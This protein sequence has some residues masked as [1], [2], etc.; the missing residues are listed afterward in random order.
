LRNHLEAEHRAALA[1]WR[2][3]QEAGYV[4][5]DLGQALE[6]E[7]SEVSWEAVDRLQ[8]A[9]ANVTALGEREI[10]LADIHPSRWQPRAIVFDAEQLWELAK[11][12]E[13]MGL[14]NA[15]SVFRAH[16]GYELVAGERRTRAMVGL[17]L[18]KHLDRYTPKKCVERLARFGLGGLLDE[19]R[20]A[21]TAH[22]DT[23][24]A[25]V[26]PDGDTEHL[27]LVAVMENIDRQALTPLE[28][29][30]AFQG[31]VED[32][33]WSQRELARRIGKSQGY[34]Q[35]RLA[36]TG[37]TEAAQEAV[38][39]RV[40]NT[41]HARA[42]SSVPEPLQEA[43]TEWA[44]AAV[45]RSDT[46][47]TTRQ[48][49]NRARQVAAFVDPDRW[50]P[51]GEV[52]YRPLERNRLAAIRWALGLADLEWRSEEILG[53]GEVGYSEHNYLAQR[54]RSVVNNTYQFEKVLEALGVNI[55][56]DDEA[57]AFAMATNRTCE[58]CIFADTDLELESDDIP[59][60]CPRWVNDEIEACWEWIGA[61][62]PVVIPVHVYPLN[63]ILR[64]IKPAG[65]YQEPFEHFRN[66][67]H[68]LSA[69]E[70]A[71]RHEEEKARR[72]E[73]KARWGHVDVMRRFYAWQQELTLLSHFQAHACQKCR[74]YEPLN[75]EEDLPPCR[76][77]RDPLTDRYS[78]DV[79]APEYGAL[80]TEAL[81]RAIVL[82]RCEQFAYAELPTMPHGARI[83]VEEGDRS[84][85]LEW[86]MAI[87][88][89]RGRGYDRDCL[90][91]VLRWLPYE[92]PRDEAQNWDRLTRYLQDLWARI[93]PRTIATLFD[94]MISETHARQGYS[95]PVTLYN[96]VTGK[97]ETWYPVE[98]N[99]LDRES[100][101]YGRPYR[102]AAEWP[103]LWTDEEVE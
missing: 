74:H 1:H 98:F 75:L 20:L 72:Q 35:Q 58:S 49:A 48:V 9:I 95:G 2:E 19:E 97:E 57:Q 83:A 90:W 76:F 29:G 60:H 25:N 67:Q 64:E 38:N 23:I 14:I 66:V 71:I 11:S 53:L 17:A 3:L 56:D 70:A 85:V 39:T 10:S 27:H 12:I 63:S 43:V 84:R 73:E 103:D 15:I 24:R 99:R 42:I 80:V 8:A 96:P 32:Y 30:V 16:G 62:D 69:Y 21:L 18:G 46:P 87:A 36:L 65:W 51:N 31:L 33:D 13:E 22:G 78:D 92:R 52:I 59:V 89:G 100:E 7:A 40:I 102:W 82:P 79:R 55:K 45:T 101:F 81:V 77:V 50:L 86:M 68:Y 88:K 5:P 61:G 26:L 37:L 54:P 34:V 6:A 47:A 28:E 94:V 91:G 41:T 44:V 4:D 93:G